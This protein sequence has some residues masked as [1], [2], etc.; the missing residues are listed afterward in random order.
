M[1]NR[2][3]RTGYKTLDL[4]YFFTAGPDE[5]RAWTV[6]DGTKAP[7]AAGV[8]HSDFEKGF[9]CAEIMKFEDLA[10]FGS[11]VACKNEGKYHQ[12]GKEFVVEDGDV[13]FFK[14]N[15]PQKVKK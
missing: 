14:F 12:K 10:K 9:I 4:I 13:I 15:A 5:V 1:M 6:R 2:I 3:I 8:I 11:E 7:Q